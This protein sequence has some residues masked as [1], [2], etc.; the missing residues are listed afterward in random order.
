MHFSK[1]TGEQALSIVILLAM[2]YKYHLKI[3]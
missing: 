1:P 2:T 3:S